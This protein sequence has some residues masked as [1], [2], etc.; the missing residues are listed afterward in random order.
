MK[1]LF[2]ILILILTSCKGFVHGDNS[3]AIHSLLKNGYKSDSME[4]FRS[5]IRIYDSVLRLDPDN[6]IALVNLGRAKISLG[7]TSA[8]LRELTRSIKIHP[9]TQ[10]FVSRAMAEFYR[11]PSQSLKDLELAD[12]S[13]PE[14]AVIIGLL[15]HYYTAIDPIRDSG[16]Y[17]AAHTFKLSAEKPFCYF[18]VMNAYLRYSDYPNLIKVSDSIIARF[19]DSAYAYNNKGLAELM[20]GEPQ[21]AKLD[22]RTSLNLDSSNAWAYRNMGLVFEKMNGLD[23]GCYYFHLAREK[24][25]TRQY[26]KDLDSLVQRFCGNR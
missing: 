18:T 24:D 17:Y 1:W 26:Q 6:Y 23:S 4:D 13:S 2:F 25:K 10:A 21:H 14:N 9:T 5:S 11:D 8:G 20:L 16:L 15:T 19:P 3:E 7:D 12:K 22:I